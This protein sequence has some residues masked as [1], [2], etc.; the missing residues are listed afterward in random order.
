MM[1]Y[2]KRWRM[3]R[4]ISR[5]SGQFS[6]IGNRNG[7]FSI[8]S[9]AEA[10]AA[11]NFPPSPRDALSYQRAAERASVFAPLSNY[12]I[13]GLTPAPVPLVVLQEPPATPELQNRRFQ[14]LL[15][16]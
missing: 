13:I 7:S 9:N 10:T 2:G 5:L 14:P 12:S 11:K 3:H 15:S 4:L 1:L 8:E 6:T 16:A